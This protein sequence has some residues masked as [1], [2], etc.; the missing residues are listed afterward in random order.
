MA[1]VGRVVSALLMIQTMKMILRPTLEICLKMIVDS[2]M[3]ES[4]FEHMDLP[5]LQMFTI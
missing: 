1:V 2:G 3:T 5:F 4:I